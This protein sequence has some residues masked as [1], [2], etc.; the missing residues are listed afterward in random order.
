MRRRWRRWWST[1]W[2]AE[3]GWRGPGGGS[4]EGGEE[5]ETRCDNVSFG[6]GLNGSSV[7]HVRLRRERPIDFCWSVLLMFL[8][9]SIDLFGVSCCFLLEC[10]VVFFVGEAQILI[11]IFWWP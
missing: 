5:E 9:R 11:N 7:P 10:S 3:V 2:N 6:S 1:D 8:E 4:D